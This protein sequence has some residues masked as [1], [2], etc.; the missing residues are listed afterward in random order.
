MKWSLAIGV[1]LSFMLS[2]AGCAARHPQT[3]LTDGVE[4]AVAQH[5]L[6]LKVEI[7]TE[8]L[9]QGDQSLDGSSLI[10]AGQGTAQAL[11]SASQ[12]ASAGGGNA[13]LGLGMII[14]SALASNASQSNAEHELSDAAEQHVATTRE[15]I[16]A[17]VDSA[18]LHQALS[19]ALQHEGISS[20]G[21][22]PYQ[23]LLAP[24]VTLK[25]GDQVLLLSSQVQLLYAGKIL[26]RGFLDVYQV[27]ADCADDCLTN[28]YV[29]QALL[30]RETVEQCLQETVQLMLLDWKSQH[31]AKNT[32]NERTLKIEVANLR[33]VER[34]RLNNQPGSRLRYLS[35]DGRIKSFPKNDNLLLPN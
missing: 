21:N 26:Y 2:I 27:G 5:G 17:H 16:S 10:A 7:A 13:A 8:E 25:Q 4:Q 24:R 31:F 14:G 18:W 32:D 28:W 35:L 6:S 15:Q 29:N 33:Q 12:G 1:A 3:L 20:H 23:L 11:F 34:G 22:S 19:T 9:L 30:Y